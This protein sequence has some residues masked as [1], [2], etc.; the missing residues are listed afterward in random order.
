MINLLKRN[1]VPIVFFTF[2]FMAIFSFFDFR[3]EEKKLINELIKYNYEAI[4]EIQN[5]TREIDNFTLIAKPTKESNDKILSIFA[6]LES[7][8]TEAN[9][10]QKKANISDTYTDYTKAAKEYYDV[11]LNSVIENKHIY[12]QK[13]EIL[14]RI[15]EFENLDI[16]TIDQ[17][18]FHIKVLDYIIKSTKSDEKTFSFKARE[19]LNKNII[20]GVISDEEKQEY[21][22]LRDEAKLFV[23]KG[24][25]VVTFTDIDNDKVYKKFEALDKIEKYLRNQHNLRTL[26]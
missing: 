21:T 22:N 7:R 11:Y 17:V 16:S 24:M 13:Y 25:H 26:D 9:T 3:T 6:S 10:N 1:I 18:N 2:V 19:I 8:V 15:Q 12:S 4:V 5:K 23:P 20:D 14:D